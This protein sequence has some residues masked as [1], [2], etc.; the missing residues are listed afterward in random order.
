MHISSKTASKLIVAPFCDC[1]LFDTLI[2]LHGMSASIT[3]LAWH[4]LCWFFALYIN[5]PCSGEDHTTC[6]RLHRPCL[7]NKTTAAR[8]DAHTAICFL[9]PCILIDVFDRI[10]A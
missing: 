1:K 6:V 8:I 5:I 2:E 4:K 7:P 10:S 9:R 3:K